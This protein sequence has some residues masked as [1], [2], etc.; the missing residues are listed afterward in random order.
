VI[1]LQGWV[2]RI[3]R[4][5]DVNASVRVGSERQVS[6]GQIRISV[7]QLCILITVPQLTLHAG[8]ATLVLRI[9]FRR[10]LAP[11][12]IPRFVHGGFLS[13]LNYALSIRLG[14]GFRSSEGDTVISARTTALEQ[15]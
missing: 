11:I 15:V 8:V 4:E 12:L 5:Q 2:K 7:L 13:S 14:D 1:S 3:W 9:L 10:A 6:P